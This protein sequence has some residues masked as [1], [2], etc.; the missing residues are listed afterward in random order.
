[1]AK[2]NPTENYQERISQHYRNPRNFGKITG[3]FLHGKAHNPVCGDNIEIYLKV[4]NGKI[5]DVKFYGKG[6]GVSTASAS[7]LTEKVKGMTVT[8]AKNLK[9]EDIF[10]MLGVKKIETPRIACALLCLDALL[11]SLAQSKG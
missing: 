4:D 3:R 7:M 1:M 10:D 8:M 9:K 11:K 6:C 2:A 5:T